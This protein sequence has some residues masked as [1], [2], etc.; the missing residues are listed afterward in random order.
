VDHVRGGQLA[1]AGDL[2]VAGVATAE[3]PAL[4]EQLRPGGPVDRAVDAAA[5]EQ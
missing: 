1:G 2:R 4:L 3:R 5:A